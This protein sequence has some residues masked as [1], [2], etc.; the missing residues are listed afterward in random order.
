MNI[1]IPTDHVDIIKDTERGHD[2]DEA[3]GAV[4]C[5]K[6]QLRGSVFNHR[7]SPLFF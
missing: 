1:E 5:L 7:D 2:S 3:K 6:N 4:N